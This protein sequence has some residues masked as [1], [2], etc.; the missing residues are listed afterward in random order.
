MERKKWFT[1]DENLKTNDMVYFK[2]DDSPLGATWHVGKV[3]SVKVGKDSKLREINIAYEVM[4]EDEPGWRHNVVVRP[5]T[6]CIKLF[7]I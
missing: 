5:A 1:G 6:Q 7:E 2:I 3:D 4:T